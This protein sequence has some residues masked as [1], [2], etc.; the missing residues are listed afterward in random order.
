MRND[1]MNRYNNSEVS[2]K[3]IVLKRDMNNKII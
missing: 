3:K 1:Y 2:N